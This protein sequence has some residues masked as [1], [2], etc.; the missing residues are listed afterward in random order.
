MGM[1]YLVVSC[2]SARFLFLVNEEERVQVLER[3]ESQGRL[4]DV[5]DSG[6][7][8]FLGTPLKHLPSSIR[9]AEV[10]VTSG[11]K[12]HEDTAETHALATLLCEAFVAGARVID[13]KS[14]LIQLDPYVPSSSS[15]LIRVLT[16]SGRHQGF[17][18]RSYLRLKNILE[19]SLAL[20][21]LLILSPILAAA[22]IA[23]RLSSPGPVFYRQTRRALGGP[24]FEMIKFR[25]MRIDAEANGPVW[26]SAQSGDS[27]LTPIGGFLRSSHIDELPQLWN[28]ARGELSFVGPRP[29]RP[30]FCERLEK[31]VPLF[32]LRTLVK[33]G[34][35]GWAQ[36][37]QGYA[38]S[39]EDSRRKLEY[40][41]Y[42]ILNHSLP[43][44][45]AVVFGTVKIVLTGGTEG[46]KRARLKIATSEPAPIRRRSFLPR[47][48]SGQLAL[49]GG[50]REAVAASEPLRSASGGD[51]VA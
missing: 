33:P 32:G 49:R 41:L 8:D 5:I 29:E 39:V 46:K 26:A 30:I 15:D 1:K 35:T 27:R 24:D 20:L 11:Q 18:I 28:V 10:W 48:A 4:S 6:S 13:F 12:P 9:N 2:V 23:I 31:D 21:M 43:M 47:I 38:N 40:D 14:A 36:I 51:P 44:D 19:P 42:Y 34:I 22:A 3:L 37:K 16:Q 7:T 45:L 17:W 25:S 50:R